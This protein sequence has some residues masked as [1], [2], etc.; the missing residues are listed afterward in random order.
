MWNK[1]F[2][3]LGERVI[4]AIIKM[5]QKYFEEQAH[6]KKVKKKIKEI[7]RETED[8]EERARRVSDMLDL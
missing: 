5:V 1:L 7:M 4:W 2:I 8:P 3:L 6:K